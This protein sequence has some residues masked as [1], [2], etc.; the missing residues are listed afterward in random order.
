M[1]AGAIVNARIGRVVWGAYDKKAGA[2]GSV[3]NLNDLPLNHKP[4]LQGGVLADECSDLLSSYFRGKR[5]AAKQKKQEQKDK[6]T[7]PPEE[8]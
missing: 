6:N 5:S 4:I 8:D 2:F 1:C 7:P 3:L